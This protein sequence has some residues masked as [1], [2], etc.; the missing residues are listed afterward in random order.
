MKSDMLFR[1]G[2]LLKVVKVVIFKG[3][4]HQI[5][6]QRRDPRSKKCLLFGWM[7]GQTEGMVL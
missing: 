2:G 4:K 1:E 6:K 5:L 3:R 7:T